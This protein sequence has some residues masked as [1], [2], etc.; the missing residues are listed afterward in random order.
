MTDL[1]TAQSN[2]DIQYFHSDVKN[3]NV[4]LYLGSDK[5]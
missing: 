1:L 5:Q 2:I 4:T 3:L